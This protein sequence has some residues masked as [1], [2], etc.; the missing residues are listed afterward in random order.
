MDPVKN[1]TVIRGIGVGYKNQDMV[2]DYKAIVDVQKQIHAEQ[3]K[4]N[5]V[6]GL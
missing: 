5:G 6:T 3:L 4:I 1:K 2:K